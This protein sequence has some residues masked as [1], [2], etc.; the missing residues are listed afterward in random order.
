VTLGA[1]IDERQVQLTAMLGRMRIVTQRALTASN[2]RMRGQPR[3]LLSNVLVAGGAQ[4]PRV[5]IQKRCVFRGVRVVAIGARALRKCG[6]NVRKLLLV[7]CGVVTQ[8]ADV[9]LV[10]V[11]DSGERGGWDD[12]QQQSYAEGT[13]SGAHH[14]SPSSS[15]TEA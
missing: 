11:P 12:A 15:A 6:M 3:G 1:L 5:V 4:L 9:G 10:D 13:N 2:R 14:R 8:V 7:L